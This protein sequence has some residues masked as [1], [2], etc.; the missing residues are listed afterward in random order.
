MSQHKPVI[1]L[2]APQMGENIGAAARAMCNFG[3]DTL[4]IVNPRD[5]WPNNQ[6]SESAT[7]NAVGAFDHMHPVEVFDNTA[8]ALKE[9]HTIYAT[10]ARARDMRK[11][12]MTARTTA[13]DIA[14]K[15]AQGL[16]TAIMFGGERAGLTNEDIALAHNIITI[17]TNPNFSSLNLAQSVLLMANEI[18]QATHNNSTEAQTPLGDSAPVTHEELN[19]MITR[20]ENELETRNFFRNPD[21]KP[22]MMNNIRTMLTRANLTDQETRTFQGIISALIG[23][24]VK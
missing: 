18:F 11:P 19:E 2:I 22:T 3:L 1:I 20:L 13:Q 17:P 24:K 10:T 7:A 8:D 21:M 14:D 6:P 12:V 4:K 5:G 15:Q 16:R 23:N 9:F